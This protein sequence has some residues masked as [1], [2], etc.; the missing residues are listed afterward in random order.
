MHLQFTSLGHTELHGNAM[1]ITSTISVVLFSNVV[2]CLVLGVIYHSIE[3]SLISYMTMPTINKVVKPFLR[4][5]IV[6][7]LDSHRHKVVLV[8]ATI[9]F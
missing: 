5:T 4:S 2:K 3:L 7:G 8:Q 9:G 6:Y 1:M